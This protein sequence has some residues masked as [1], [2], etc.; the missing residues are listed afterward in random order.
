MKIDTI[1]QNMFKVEANTY[2]VV[3]NGG[4]TFG[5]KFFVGDEMLVV[6]LPAEKIPGLVE[7][8]QSSL[9]R[10]KIA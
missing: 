9:A 3:Y 8:I 10:G 4:G 2:S 6:D 7:L 1:A 5:I